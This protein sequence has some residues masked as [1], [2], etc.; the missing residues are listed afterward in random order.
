MMPQWARARPVRR[1]GAAL[2]LDAERDVT[3]S[4]RSEPE[5][6]NRRTEQRDHRRPHRGREM[7]RGAVVRHEYRRPPDQRRPSP[8]RQ[9]AAGGDDL[10]PPFAAFAISSPSPASSALPT[11][12]TWARPATAA[13]SSAK[14]GRRLL[15]HI[16]PGASAT[17]VPSSSAAARSSSAVGRSWGG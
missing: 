12:T 7:E 4:Q 5:V 2:E 3:R 1:A 9:L 13:A 8:Q 14:Y 16:E 10:L 6:R 11:T 15:P 17:N